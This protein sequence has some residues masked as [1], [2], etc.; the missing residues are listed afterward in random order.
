MGIK[1]AEQ[2]QGRNRDRKATSQ[3]LRPAPHREDQ[4]YGENENKPGQ[5]GQ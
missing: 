4:A 5:K 2:Q 3:M 1:P